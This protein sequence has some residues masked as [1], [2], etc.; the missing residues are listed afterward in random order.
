MILDDLAPYSARIMIGILFGV[1]FVIAIPSVRLMWFD[2][3]DYY[4][5]QGVAGPFEALDENGTPGAGR[6][7]SRIHPGQSF[8]WISTLCFGAGVSAQSSVALRERTTNVVVSQETFEITPLDR[9]CGPKL[10]TLEVPSDAPPGPYEVDR[11]DLITPPHGW[12]IS[13]PLPPIDIE[14]TAP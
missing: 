2:P 1:I 12:P 7:I 9:R 13:N 8:A 6:P 14:V 11:N 3:R 10:F 4:T 5:Y